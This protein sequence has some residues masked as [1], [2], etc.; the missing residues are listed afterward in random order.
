MLERLKVKN[1][2]VD[3]V[4]TQIEFVPTALYD[5][6]FNYNVNILKDG[7]P[8]KQVSL[9]HAFFTDTFRG[10]YLVNGVMYTRQ[11]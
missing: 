9:P 5:A 4:E 10:G 8:I 7:I 3:G 2:L 6:R 11:Q 1:I